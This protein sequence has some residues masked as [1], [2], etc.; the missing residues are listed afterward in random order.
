VIIFVLVERILTRRH[1]LT[2]HALGS[3][4]DPPPRGTKDLA[5]EAKG[6]QLFYKLANLDDRIKNADQ[7]GCIWAGVVRD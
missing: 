6:E 5:E 4:L 3:Y 7:V 2:Q 1:R